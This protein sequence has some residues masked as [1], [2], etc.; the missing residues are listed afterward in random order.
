MVAVGGIPARPAE[1]SG[2]AL[3][4]REVEALWLGVGSNTFGISEYPI[5]I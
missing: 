5:V 4:T 3:T 2:G 1:K